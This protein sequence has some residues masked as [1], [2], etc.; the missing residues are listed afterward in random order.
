[1]KPL[2][3]APLLFYTATPLILGFIGSLVTTPAIPIWYTSLIKPDFTPPSWIFAP[4]WTILYILMGIAAYIISTTKKKEERHALQIYWAQLLV[5]I[6]WSLLFFGLRN[7]VLALVD[8]VLLW[9]MIMLTIR[10]FY[11]LSS[12]ASYL[13]IPYLLWVSFAL[14]LNLTIVILN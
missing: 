6:L 12:I 2:K 4:A 5:N 1:M 11:K 8:I 3:T 7:P 14:I 13:L 9:G 10:A